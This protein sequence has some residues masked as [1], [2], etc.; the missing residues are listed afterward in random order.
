MPKPKSVEQDVAKILSEAIDMKQRLALARAINKRRLAKFLD[1]TAALR[2]ILHTMELHMAGDTTEL[3]GAIQGISD[4]VDTIIQDLVAAK[5]QNAA[6]VAQANADA[7]AKLGGLKSKLDQAV[8]DNTPTPTV[9]A[10]HFKG[11]KGGK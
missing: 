6:D 4:E 9:L 2:D 8:A 1:S 10:R 7:V 5:G 11:A 3:D